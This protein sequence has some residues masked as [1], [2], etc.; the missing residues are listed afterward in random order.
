MNDTQLKKLLRTADV[1]QAIWTSHSDPK[2]T[3]DLL[4]AAVILRRTMRRRVVGIGTSAA[5]VLIAVTAWVFN[6]DHGGPA[7]RP[8]INVHDAEMLTIKLTAVKG[9]IELRQRV[10]TE[11]QRTEA[12]NMAETELARLQREVSPA[13][14]LQSMLAFRREVDRSAIIS[15][16]YAERLAKELNDPKGAATEFRGIAERYNDT[17]WAA[18]ATRRLAQID[19]L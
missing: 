1:A 4:E 8:N 7:V 10:V 6:I 17:Q 13:S 11:L 15:L 5:L 14:K 3:V 2:L 12:V 18:T 19:S 16:I 9:E